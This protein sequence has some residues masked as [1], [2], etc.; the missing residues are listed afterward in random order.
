MATQAI[1]SI[2]SGATGIF[3]VD[4]KE[5]KNN[6]ICPTEINAGRFFTTSNFFSTAAKIYN[7]PKANMPYIYVLLAY[8]E[9]IPEGPKY[10]ILPENLYW[11]RHIDCSEHLVAEKDLS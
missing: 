6:N 2:D 4:M 1:L 8:K 7:I 3:C 10:N 9:K 11:I 5:D